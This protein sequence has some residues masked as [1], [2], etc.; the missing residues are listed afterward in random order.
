ML[1]IKTAIKNVNMFIYAFIVWLNDVVCSFIIV[2]FLYSDVYILMP[3]RY[4]CKNKSLMN[5]FYFYK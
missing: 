5:K 4:K 3:T 1:N 2:Q